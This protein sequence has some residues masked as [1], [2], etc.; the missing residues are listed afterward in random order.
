MSIAPLDRRSRFGNGGFSPERAIDQSSCGARQR[1]ETPEP[2][3]HRRQASSNR[4]IVMVFVA[5]RPRR[6]LI[7]EHDR[8]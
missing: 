6:V 8:N 7:I 4:R 5:I 3:A 2:H 1:V